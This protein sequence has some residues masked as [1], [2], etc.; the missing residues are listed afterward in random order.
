M[1]EEVQHDTGRRPIQLPTTSE[2]R[3]IPTGCL[4]PLTLVTSEPASVDCLPKHSLMSVEDYRRHQ[5][6]GKSPRGAY[7]RSRSLLHQERHPKRY[8]MA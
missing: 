6:R 8:G 5:S 7:S 2:P 4:F 1:L 3:K